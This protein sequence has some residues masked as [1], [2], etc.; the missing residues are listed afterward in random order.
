MNKINLLSLNEFDKLLGDTVELDNYEI[1]N[2]SL[3]NKSYWV[4]NSDTLDKL[5]IYLN[6]LRDSTSILLLPISTLTSSHGNSII[7][8]ISIILN[9]NFYNENLGRLLSKSTLK[10]GELFIRRLLKDLYYMDN[11]YGT[12]K[13]NNIGLFNSELW[14]VEKMNY[15]FNE[16][17]EAIK[18]EFLDEK[19]ISI[20]VNGTIKSYSKLNE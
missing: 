16:Y 6:S 17:T 13:V 3:T 4:Y 18:S 1:S 8:V 15:Y 14:L 2:C 19:I 7:D 12:M 5:V 9:I 10:V 20:K 11:I